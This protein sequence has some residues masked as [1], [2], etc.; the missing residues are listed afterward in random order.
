MAEKSVGTGRGRG[1]LGLRGR[2]GSP[3]GAGDVAQNNEIQRRVPEI[4]ENGR[5]WADV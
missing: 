2:F 1:R 4:P 3:E 5:I